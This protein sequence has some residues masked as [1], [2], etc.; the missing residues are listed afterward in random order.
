MAVDG[1]DANGMP[2]L[3]EVHRSQQRMERTLDG[4]VQTLD[5]KFDALAK[6]I[7]VERHR[8]SN[9]IHLE[10]L[11]KDFMSK[12]QEKFKQIDTIEKAKVDA[13]SVLA[14]EAKLREVEQVKADAALVAQLDAKVEA[15]EIE[16]ETRHAADKA[17]REL[18][19]TVASGKWFGGVAILLNI[20]VAAKVLGWF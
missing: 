4:L 11:T 17:V 3:G 7:S 6:E 16:R 19:Q 1:E 14:L 8:V 12:A 9:M 13:A 10:G 15:L 2:T 20:A 5:V 18:K